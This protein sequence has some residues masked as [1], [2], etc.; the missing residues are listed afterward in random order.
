MHSSIVYGDV[1][2][3][4]VQI[5]AY[6]YKEI[7]KGIEVTELDLFVSTWIKLKELIGKKQVENET[8]SMIP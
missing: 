5:L 8:L 3:L 2:R 6:S 1:R 7:L 4:D